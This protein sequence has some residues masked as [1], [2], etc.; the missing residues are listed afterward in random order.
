MA[1]VTGA[2]GTGNSYSYMGGRLPIGW[3]RQLNTLM[4]ETSSTL[5]ENFSITRGGPLH[6]LLVRLGSAGDDR[7]LVVK[8]ALVT[9][10]FLWL[11]MFVLSLMY[12]EAYG[13]SV[14][15]VFLRDIA[16]N[17]RFLIAVPILILAESGIDKTWRLLVHHFLQSG[18]VTEKELPAFESVI[19]NTSRWRDRVWPEAVMVLLAFLPLLFTRTEPLMSSVSN[20]HGG[21]MDGISPAGRWFNL[22]ATPVFRFL[23]MR[24]VWRMFLWTSFL[25]RVARLNLYYVATHTDLAAGL[26]FLSEGQKAFSPIVFAGGSV[27]A[28]Q[29]GN[30]ILYEGATLSSQKL[31]MIAY[32]VLAILCLLAPLTVV[33]PVLFKIKRRAL[34]EY[35]ALVTR[36]NQQ[37]DQ[38]WILEKQE[39]A[40]RMLGHPDASS[41]VDLGSSFTVVRQMSL[42]PIDKP[43]LIILAVSA[44][45]PMIAVALY[46]TPTNELVHLVLK[47]LG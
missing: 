28:A 3:S 38:K 41:L 22:V 33:S 13:T 21:V 8:R 29:V 40:E 15:V 44:A 12:G 26:G 23:L 10:L 7:R 34:R 27:I 31:P 14:K 30:A 9:S 39:S 19:A 42:V 4:D 36:H 47:M 20:W 32:G 37:F 2:S 5:V 35:G 1:F 25:W 6:R 43:T 18:L 17:V 45:I 24:W 16:V 11:P 46:A